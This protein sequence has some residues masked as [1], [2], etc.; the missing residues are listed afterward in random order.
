MSKD[1]FRKIVTFSAFFVL[2]FSALAP[3]RSLGSGPDLARLDDPGYRAAISAA[4]RM[5]VQHMKNLEIPGMQLAVYSKGTLVCSESFGMAD[6]EK[7]IPVTADTSFRIGSVSKS[8]TTAALARLVEQ[9]RINLDEPISKYVPSFPKKEWPITTRQLAG[10]TSGIRHYRTAEEAES[11]RHYASV[12]DSLEIFK[13]DPLLFE[14]GTRVQYSSYGYVLLSAA[15]ETVSKQEFPEL[16]GEQVFLPLGMKHTSM[17]Y[18]DR[19]IADR[20]QFYVLDSEERR[21]VAPFVDHSSKWASGGM[22]S[23]AD[24]LTRFGNALLRGKFLGTE[25]T[26]TLF[27]SGKT[28]DGRETGYGLGWEILRD[29]YDRKVIVN[30]G[31]LPSARAVL[32]IYPE[33]DLVIAI[34]ANTGKNIFFNREE[35]LMIAD[36]FLN[37]SGL[38]PSSEEKRSAIGQYSYST[39]FDGEDIDGRIS[40]FEQDGKLLGTMTIPNKF[41][42]NRVI[43]VPVVRVSRGRLTILGLPGNW[44]CLDLRT[45]H[46][47]ISGRWRFGP[48]K[49]NLKESRDN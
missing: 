12:L 9:G 37:S 14:P 47:V 5:I 46:S 38:D 30:D 28:R 2:T 43:P 27:T 22:V 45:E 4:K 13:D 7:K 20:S 23:T 17:D 6:L 18:P 16:M 1:Q 24:D 3:F 26:K 44:V 34:L 41:F 36:L 10:H 19:K 25:I 48:I 8:L 15:L 49:G 32:A 21:I 33:D 39:S 11:S 31:S 35:A 40:I 29:A 42:G